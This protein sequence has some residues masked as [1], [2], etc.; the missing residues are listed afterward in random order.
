MFRYYDSV[1]SLSNVEG[2]SVVGDRIG[3]IS[4]ES[5]G[6]NRRGHIEDS[7][8]G[9][10]IFNKELS[11][12]SHNELLSNVGQIVLLN[13]FGDQ[14]L[15][16]GVVNERTHEA[17]GIGVMVKGLECGIAVL[18]IPGDDLLGGVD[19][20]AVDKSGGVESIDIDGCGV[21]VIS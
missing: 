19:V 5:T 17:S 12:D 6:D 13:S 2:I 10:E 4:I 20:E 1:R 7:I 9:S 3:T 8:A 15:E 18:C 21:H 11:M 16:G 14:N